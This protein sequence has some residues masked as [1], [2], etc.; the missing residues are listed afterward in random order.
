MK[1]ATGYPIQPGDKIAYPNRQGSCMWLETGEVLT[2]FAGVVRVA[3]KNGNVVSLRKTDRAV[4]YDAN[5]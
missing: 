2:V 1:D 4:V 5:A 3:K